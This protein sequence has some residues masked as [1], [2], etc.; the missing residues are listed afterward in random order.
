MR[1][2]IALAFALVIICSLS[3][4]SD[5][6]ISVTATTSKSDEAFVIEDGVLIQCNDRTSDE[7][8]IPDGVTVISE[9]ACGGIAAVS[10]KIPDSVTVI[11]NSAFGWCKSLKYITIPE[12]VTIIGDHAF[13]ECSK[14]TDIVIEDGVKTIGSCAFADVNQFND[15]V[16]SEVVFNLPDSVEQIG[17]SAFRRSEQTVTVIHR[18]VEYTGDEI[19]E[20]YMLYPIIEE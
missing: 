9:G 12:S 13:E 2:I 6:S 14:L 8:V 11:E 10:I 3:G 15:T 7:I 17:N 18:G 16:A 19:E 20:L 1:K 5:D 4:C